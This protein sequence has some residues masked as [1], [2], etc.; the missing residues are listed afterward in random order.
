MRK[1]LMPKRTIIN[2]PATGVAQ[3]TEL[4]CGFHA[5]FTSMVLAGEV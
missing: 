2:A 5:A 1:A 3:M 4:S